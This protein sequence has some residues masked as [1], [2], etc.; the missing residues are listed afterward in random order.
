MGHAT[1]EALVNG[2]TKRQILIA[3]LACR[4]GRTISELAA[5]LNWRPASVRAEITRVRQEGW[6]VREY[7]SNSR[8]KRFRLNG[9]TGFHTNSH[10]RAELSAED[11]VFS[12]LGLVDG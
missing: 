1:E 5:A 9:D 6:P 10:G 7:Q 3:L 8:P 11:R 12:A 2:L 4:D